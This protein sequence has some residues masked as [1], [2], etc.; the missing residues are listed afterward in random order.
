MNILPTS[1]ARMRGVAAV[2]F[3][4]VCFMFFLL[5][6]SALEFARVLYIHNTLQEVTRRTAR[7]MTVRWIDQEDAAKTLALF[8][9]ASLPGGA[10]IT[11][12]SIVIE[13]LNSSGAAVTSVPADPGDNLSACG[14]A[15]RVNSCIY[16]VRVSIAPNVFYSPMVSMVRLLPIEFPESTVTMHAESMG[17]A[18]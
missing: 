8:G 7:E 14:D 2:E 5:V 13:Y 11:K 9:G 4:L 16:S 17:F 10:E 12:S 1:P 15:A 3:A 6:F 18:N